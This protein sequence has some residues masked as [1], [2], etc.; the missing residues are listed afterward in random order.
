M[1]V[2]R[3]VLFEIVNTLGSQARSEGEDHGGHAKEC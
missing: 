3:G 2:R 1:L